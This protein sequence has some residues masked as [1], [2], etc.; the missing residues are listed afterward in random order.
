MRALSSRRA[1]LTCVSPHVR[2]EVGTL[3]VGLAAAGELA[4]VSGCALPRPGSASPLGFTVLGGG[5]RGEEVQQGGGWRGQHHAVHAGSV[6]LAGISVDVELPVKLLAVMGRV[7][8]GSLILLWHRQVGATVHVWDCLV[9]LG[10]QLARVRESVNPKG[11]P[12]KW[13]LLLLLLLLGMVMVQW[14]QVRLLVNH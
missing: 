4:I 11:L 1:L 3:G 10:H 5:H 13:M 12:V 9:I 7:D 2:L 6:D 8:G 14:N